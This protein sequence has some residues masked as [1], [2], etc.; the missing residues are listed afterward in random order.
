MNKKIY[1]IGIG[2][3]GISAI[4][5]F[6]LHAGWEVFGSDST[7]SELISNLK[8][9]GCD[10]II[11]V[12]ETRV[13]NS[14][15]KVIYTEAVPT[16]QKE[17]AK[18]LVNKI[19]T[20]TYPE[21]LASIAN[22]KKLIAVA[23]T[24]GKSTTSSL[25]SLVLKNSDESVNSVVGTILKEFNNK[26]AYFSDSPYFVIE[27]CEY[28]RSFL[29]YKPSVGIIVNIEIDH[30]DYYKD[31][32]DYISAYKEFID[33]IRPGGFA[34]LN[35]EDENCKKLLGLRDDIEYIEIFTNTYKIHSSGEEIEF[36]E[37]DMKVPGSHI[38]F[39]AQIAYVVGIMVGVHEHKVIEALEDYTGVWR[40][41]EQIGNTHNGNLLMSDYGHHPT[42]ITL[43]L[44]ALKS[45]YPTKHLYTIFQ[46]HQYNRTLELLED[47][48]TCFK[49]TDTLIIPDIYES[50]DS[51][52]DK[53]QINSE[54][55]VK[56]IK[57]HN[58]FDGQ[59]LEN[60]LKLIQDFD[61]QNADSAIILLL[62]A[63]NV[64]ELR[65]KI[66]TKK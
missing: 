58:K 22:N 30:L 42:E 9:E 52:E 20:L 35:G 38:L 29:K 61:K 25:A 31:L 46:P 49:A 43:T 27:A 62:G 16:T 18:A 45:K 32:E 41:M 10:I 47:F 44:D 57:H 21:A 6:Y 1:I 63:G 51:E 40:R 39:D 33:N 26:N 3:I 64:D 53:A 12:D 50:R 65:Y 2:G 23:G 13:N 66:E 60:T 37:I 19:E 34:I 15:D 11:G 8:K 48:K 24:H 55:L 4:A 36:P 56:L 54:K 14:F 17:L 7:D 5:R 59:G 28:K